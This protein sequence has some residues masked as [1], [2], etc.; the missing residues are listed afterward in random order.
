MPTTNG[1]LIYR[2]IRP[3]FF[4]HS[5]EMLAGTTNPIQRTTV[6]RFVHTLAAVDTS[7]WGP[8]RFDELTTTGPMSAVAVF[9][10][11]PP[12]PAQR[13]SYYTVPKGDS[14]L[15]FSR[16]PD[17][18]SLRPVTPIELTADRW[19]T[20]SSCVFPSMDPLDLPVWNEEREVK[21]PRP[22]ANCG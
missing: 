22:E 6:S 15:E 13:A 7:Y 10:S 16:V 8:N 20:T 19:S 3:V 14:K 17:L 1:D 12:T 5:L 18:G 2:C 9:P 21:V 4:P 11:L